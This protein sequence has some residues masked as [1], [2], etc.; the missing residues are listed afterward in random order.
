MDIYAD[1]NI[2]MAEAFSMFGDLVRYDEGEENL[3][4]PLTSSKREL[5]VLLRT[6]TKINASFLK[7]V[8]APIQWIASP[9]AG[10]DHVD[11]EALKQWSIPFFH[12]PG[13]NSISVVEYI[14]SA[15]NC[16]FPNLDAFK[17]QTFFICGAG[18]VGGRL[19]KSLELLGAKIIVC[20]P[21][22]SCLG[23]GRFHYASMEAAKEADVLIFCVPLNQDGPYK[24]KRFLDETFFK[25][26]KK[27]PLFI[28]TSRGEIVESGVLLEALRRGMIK[29]IVADVYENEPDLKESELNLIQRSFLATPH[30]AGYS[31]ESKLR[32]TEMIFNELNSFYKKNEIFPKPLPPD[33]EISSSFTKLHAKKPLSISNVFWHLFDIEEA[34][35]DFKKSLLPFFSRPL[36]SDDKKIVS[37]VFKMTRPRYHQRRNAKRLIENDFKANFEKMNPAEQKMMQNLFKRL[38]EKPV[39]IRS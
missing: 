8:Q 39:F 29:D 28:N 37:S 18:N 30:I 31:F 7:K 5:G 11:V 14:L 36:S 4:K 35:K 32:A 15:V 1:R 21:P 34:S 23:D 17:K 22:L 24:T 10:F 27:S 38:E 33:A 25:S 19:A 6:T 16:Y 26:L 12:S 2:Y 9:T 20:D 3:I 13:C